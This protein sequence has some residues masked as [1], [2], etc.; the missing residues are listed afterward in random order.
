MKIT[1]SLFGLVPVSLEVTRAMS[2]TAPSS[3]SQ[4]Q[5]KGEAP[6]PVTER[7]SNPITQVGFGSSR[8]RW[9]DGR[10]RW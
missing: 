9:A 1:L 4:P 8:S 7:I 2:S 5:P 6:G 10:D 3:E